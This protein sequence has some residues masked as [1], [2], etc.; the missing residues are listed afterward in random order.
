MQL[1]STAFKENELIPARYTCQG[2][3]INPALQINNV[4]SEAISLVL[5]MYDPDAPSGNFVHWTLWNIPA[6]T[7]DIDEANVTMG[8][9]EGLTSAGSAG[10][11]GPCPGSGEHQYIFTLYA[12]DTTLKLKSETDLTGLKQ[13]MN[14][15]ILTTTT[16]MGRYQKTP[17]A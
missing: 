9:T 10:Y 17:I 14:G 4:P 5:T 6:T 1:T 15:H 3:G 16:L 13:A 12:I 8:I 7:T 11:F 2:Q